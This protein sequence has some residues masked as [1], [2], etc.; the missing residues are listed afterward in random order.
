MQ[1]TI[2]EKYW[3]AIFLDATPGAVA[4]RVPSTSFPLLDLEGRD[5]S[6]AGVSSLL[7][8]H[9]ELHKGLW[10]IDGISRRAQKES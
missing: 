8:A 10:G 5:T 9:S 2:D 7:N 4:S 6:Q 3:F 1:P